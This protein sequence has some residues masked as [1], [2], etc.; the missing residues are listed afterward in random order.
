MKNRA[1]NLPVPLGEP[2]GMSQGSGPGVLLGVKQLVPHWGLGD[3]EGLG[4]IFIVG[5][6]SSPGTLRGM[7]SQGSSPGCNGHK[8]L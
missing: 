7:S 2:A 4:G 1:A 5:M 3:E 6:S 8:Y